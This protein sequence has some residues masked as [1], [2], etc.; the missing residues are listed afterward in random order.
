[1]KITYIIE[2]LLPTGAQKELSQR[3]QIIMLIN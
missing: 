2:S 1:M 3:K